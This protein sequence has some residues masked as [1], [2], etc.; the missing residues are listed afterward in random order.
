[1]TRNLDKEV[2]DFGPYKLVI[3]QLKGARACCVL[4]RGGEKL[5]FAEADSKELAFDEMLHLLGLRQLER[6]KAQGNAPPTTA[7]V[8][9]AFSYLWDHLSRLQQRM[10]QALHQATD[11]EMSVPALADVVEFRGHRGVNLWLGLAGAMFANE[12]PRADG[13]MQHQDDG[14]PVM[15]SWFALWDASRGVWTMRPDVAEGMRQT[16]CVVGA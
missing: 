3:R 13:E 14:T 12:C 5:A 16:K 4:W 2:Q 11:Q 9:T 15:T 10:L 1:M 8:A 6:A 7:Q